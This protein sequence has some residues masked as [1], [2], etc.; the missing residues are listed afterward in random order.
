MKKFNN[1]TGYLEWRMNQ[2]EPLENVVYSFFSY[3]KPVTKKILMGIELSVKEKEV[4]RELY[5]DCRNHFEATPDQVINILE[6]AYTT[7]REI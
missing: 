6:S 3:Y 2:V 4:L 1:F 7:Y 5:I